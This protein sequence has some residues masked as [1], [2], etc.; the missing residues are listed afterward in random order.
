MINVKRKS[1]ESEILVSIAPPPIADN[2][3]EKINTPIPFLSHM[4]EQ[5]VYRWGINATVSV[6]LDKFN[7]NHVI[8]EDLGQAFG[9]AVLEYLKRQPGALSFGDSFGIIDEAKAQALVSFEDR[10]KFFFSS[11][12]EIPHFAETMLSE[13]LKV[14][15]DGFAQGARSTLQ[16]EVFSGENSHHIWEAVFRA[17]GR[18]LKNAFVTDP[19]RPDLTAGVAGKI[20]YEVTEEV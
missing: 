11:K 7:L 12:V 3:R 4:I 20:T 2:Y 17:L 9:K 16:I 6:K 10:S 1:T 14:F 19:Q 5:L 8:C 18:A 15:L 13:D